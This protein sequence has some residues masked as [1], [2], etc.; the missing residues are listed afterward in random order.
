MDATCHH[1]TRGTHQ[2]ICPKQGHCTQ[3][4]LGPTCPDSKRS[5]GQLTSAAEVHL[6]SPPM[7]PPHHTHRCRITLTGAMACTKRS[8]KPWLTSTTR[9]E[10]GQSA[11]PHTS[12]APAAPHLPACLQATVGTALTSP[13]LLHYTSHSYHH[14]HTQHPRTSPPATLQ[15]TALPC[16][17]PPPALPPLQSSQT[18]LASCLP[19][20]PQRTSP[21]CP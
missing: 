8:S 15:S 10:Q 6:T 20:S 12:Y 9:V 21:T 7:M 19:L 3:R 16:P 2:T 11:A 5:H 13:Q 1:Q 4:R 14:S 18:T 17:H